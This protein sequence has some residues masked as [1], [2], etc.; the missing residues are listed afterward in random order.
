MPE[1]PAP[2]P[3]TSAK[4]L[5]LLFLGTLTVLISGAMLTYLKQELVP[6]ILAILLC[7]FIHFLWNLVDDLLGRIVVLGVTGLLGLLVVNFVSARMSAEYDQV[8]E[9][10]PE[11]KA[12]VLDGVETVSRKLAK[13]DIFTPD[14][15]TVAPNESTGV[16]GLLRS[17]ADSAVGLVPD[18]LSELLLFLR[19][20]LS[21]MA[22][23]LVY[24]GFILAELQLLSWKVHR[25][26]P[27]TGAKVYASLRKVARGIADYFGIKTLISFLTAIVTYF[28]LEGAGVR[29]AFFWSVSTFFLNFIPNVGS[30]IALALVGTGVLMDPIS[31]KLLVLLSLGGTQ[32][33]F[34]NVIEPILAGDTLDMSA[35]AVLL[36]LAL[37][38]RIWGVSGAILSVPLTFA[39]KE[40]CRLHPS[41]RFITVFVE[42]QRNTDKVLKLRRRLWR[43]PGQYLR[44]HVKRLWETLSRPVFRDRPRIPDRHRYPPPVLSRV[45][46]HLELSDGTTRV[47]VGVECRD[48]ERVYRYLRCGE[49]GSELERYVFNS[50][51]R[52]LLREQEEGAEIAF[53]F[54]IF[55][56]GEQ[57]RYVGGAG[58]LET[59]EVDSGPGYAQFGERDLPE[60]WHCTRYAYHGEDERSQQL[61]LHEDIPWPL[62]VKDGERDVHIVSGVVRGRELFTRHRRLNELWQRV[63]MRIA[64]A[65]GYPSSRPELRFPASEELREKLRSGAWRVTFARGRRLQRFAV[66]RVYAVEGSGPATIWLKVTDIERLTLEA[67]TRRDLAGSAYAS[68]DA[69]AESISGPLVRLSFRYLGAQPEEQ[70]AKVQAKEPRLEH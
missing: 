39:V 43:F 6:L 58:R 69:L 16:G 20:I 37:W 22:A 27:G 66:G 51:R 56:K 57:L 17:S 70:P 29:F 62:R 34:G 55:R 12:S 52:L 48:G 60:A 67:V 1:E 41:L 9:F 61:V 26:F 10:F 11:Y 18:L 2:T 47:F 25:A 59:L 65:F 4:K 35:L 32:F 54:P 50:R 8:K 24:A 33:L 38:F 28:I 21:S 13:L 64:Q 3:L 63:R 46:D 7:V 36:S 49:D 19:N 42:G 31:H 15:L 40:L 44:P 23:S 5:E 68:A 14:S 30:L 53:A 45:G